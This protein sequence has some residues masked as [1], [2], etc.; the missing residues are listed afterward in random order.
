MGSGRFDTTGYSARAAARM[1]RGTSLFTHHDRVRHGDAPPVHPSMDVRL[2][3][4]REARDSKDSPESFPI[5]VVFDVTG[6]MA[7][8]PN[9]L[10]KELGKL[11]SFILDEGVVRHP[12]ILFGAVGDAF[13][14][15]APIQMGE[16]E[17]DD[18]LV[19]KCL[20]NIYLE[21]GGGGTGEESYDLAL[22]FFANHVQTDAWDKRGTKGIL[23]L[24]GDEDYYPKVKGSAVET[25]LGEKIAEDICTAQVMAR[26]QE[27]WEVFLIRPGGTSHFDNTNITQ[28]WQEILPA[29][30]V[31]RTP[32]PAQIVPTIA[33]TVAALAGRS[34]EDS[35]DALTKRG[36]DTSAVRAAQRETASTTPDALTVAPA[37]LSLPDRVRRV[38][39]L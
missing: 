10:Q 14:D 15:M 18:N 26:L 17:A 8:V 36:F 37:K 23:F 31:L 19:E 12:H 27:R 34:L 25:W 28:S 16:F 1:A 5:A 22:Y 13:S 21:G 32:Q 20:A 33:M 7:T 2:K 4:N 6:S 38:I 11:M 35:A 3:L 29:E 30:R 24:I 39:R 9:Y